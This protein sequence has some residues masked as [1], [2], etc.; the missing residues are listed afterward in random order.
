LTQL[1]ISSICALGITG[2]LAEALGRELPETLLWDHPTIQSVA[3]FLD[4]TAPHNPDEI[5]PELLE[6]AV[7]F[8]LSETHYRRLHESTASWA[9]ARA[10]PGFLINVISEHPGSVP[11]FW[12]CDYKGS[13]PLSTH[14]NQTLYAMSSGLR[15]LRHTEA[16]VH[17]L[18]K[19]YAG[20]IT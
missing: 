14:L 19:V 12:I 17:A 2:D 8:G 7:R 3:A 20:E 10:K 1:G 6:R 11:V 9:S 4:S 5:I 15:L 13:Y 16:N 18:A